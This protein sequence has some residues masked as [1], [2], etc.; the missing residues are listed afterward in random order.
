MTRKTVNL[1]IKVPI[2]RY[3]WG[4]LSPPCEYFDNEGGH[5]T[6]NLNLGDLKCSKS[7][8]VLKPKKCL[9]LEEERP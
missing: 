5:E 3:C 2:G 7:G 8:W 9:N 1:P 4:L 6:C